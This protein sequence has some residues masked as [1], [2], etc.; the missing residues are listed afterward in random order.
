MPGPRSLDPAGDGVDALE[1]PDPPLRDEVLILRR[2]TQAD[3][4]QVND[5][6]QDP[7]IAQ[8]IPIPN[9]YVLADAE[10]YIDRT[11]R[12]WRSGEKAAFAIA[13]AT[14]PTIVVGAVSLAIAGSCGN[15]A[16]WVVPAVRGLGIATRSLR[17][18]TGWGL[19]PLGLGLG[20][21]LLEIHHANAASVRVAEGAGYHHV[22]QL[23]VAAPQGTRTHHLYARLATDRL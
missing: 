1:P 17:L 14:D 2:W 11:Q 9:P 12:Q 3:A 13:D 18:L 10:A 8:F 21:V 15:A 23:E 4:S 7:A 6:C 22:G 16:Y 19:G 20:V 5:A